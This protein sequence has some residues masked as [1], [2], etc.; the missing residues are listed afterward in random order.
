ML[1]IRRTLCSAE[2]RFFPSAGFRN[3][4]LHSN[5]HSERLPRIRTLASESRRRACFQ[6]RPRTSGL[7]SRGAAAKI[8]V[9]SGFFRRICVFSSDSKDWL[10]QF[11]NV[12]L[13]VLRPQH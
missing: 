3:F 5:K 12:R 11:G 10:R 1:S 6:E 9:K 8:V 2:K 7:Y 4:H 13:V